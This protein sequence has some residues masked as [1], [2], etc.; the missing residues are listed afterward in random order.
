MESFENRKLRPL[1]RVLRLT[2]A[3]FSNEIVDRRS[4]RFRLDRE[5][6]I[7]L[8]D[9]TAEDEQ[10]GSEL[11]SPQPEQATDQQQT[12]PRAHVVIDLRA[13]FVDKE[14]NAVEG[15]N[16]VATYRASFDFNKEAQLSEI[17]EAMELEAYQY[18]FVAQAFPLAIRHFKE[19]LAAMGMNTKDLPLGIA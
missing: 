12:T 7:E 10:I 18:L 15:V 1:L 4:L 19:Q 3:N 5:V 16:A 11:A 2:K 14:S 9:P 6:A 8:E 13:H 17:A